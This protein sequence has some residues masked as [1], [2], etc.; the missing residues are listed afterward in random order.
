MLNSIG[1]I[2]NHGSSL[3][4]FWGLYSS[5]IVSASAAEGAA[6]SSASGA[7]SGDE[8]PAHEGCSEEPCSNGRM[9]MDTVK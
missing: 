8:A 5:L 4:S 6:S 9:I 7:T 3:N 1:P 2:E